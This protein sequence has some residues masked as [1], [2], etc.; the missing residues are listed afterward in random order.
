MACEVAAILRCSINDGERRR[1]PVYLSNAETGVST[2]IGN[3]FSERNARMAKASHPLGTPASARF[4]PRF[5]LPEGPHFQMQSRHREQDRPRGK[6]T[7]FFPTEN[8]IRGT[9]GQP[10]P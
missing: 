10:R 3:Q 4:S 1:S 2:K 9:S 6:N 8:A 5:C 7:A